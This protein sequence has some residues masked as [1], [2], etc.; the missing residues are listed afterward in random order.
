[1]RL[2][3][4]AVFLIVAAAS[5]S[6][7]P[8]QLIRCKV[9]ERAITHVWHKAAELRTHCRL[10][11]ADV[12]CDYSNVDPRAIDQMAWGVCD[13]LP[14]TY[15]A[16]HESEFDLVMKEGDPEHTEEAVRAIKNSCIRWLHTQHGAEEVSRVVMGNIEAGKTT[17]TILA[18][19]RRKFC[20][21]ACGYKQVSK[22]VPHND[23][24]HEEF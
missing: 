4:V 14:T 5:C 17:E 18:G 19:I 21:K 10:G 22:R 16:I 3:I 1:M 8:D 6:A 9:C 12:R 7:Y 2:S 24:V 11:H 23:P 15:H 13:A 20:R